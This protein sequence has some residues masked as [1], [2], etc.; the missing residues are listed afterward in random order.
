MDKVAGSVGFRAL[1]DELILNV[2][3]HSPIALCPFLIQCTIE[4][5]SMFQEAACKHIP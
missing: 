5:S 3:G 4:A 2:F 1:S